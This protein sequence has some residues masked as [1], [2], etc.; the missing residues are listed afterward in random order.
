MPTT[1][2]IGPDSRVRR[3]WNGYRSS[4][5]ADMAAAILRLLQEPSPDAAG[6][7]AVTPASG[8]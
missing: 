3:V 6:P 7:T 4:D 8:P 5:E 1:Y 2:L